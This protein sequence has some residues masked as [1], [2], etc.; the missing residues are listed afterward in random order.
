[1]VGRGRLFPGDPPELATRS[2]LAA[3][4]MRKDAGISAG[5]QVL[6]LNKAEFDQKTSLVKAMVC[7]ELEGDAAG[8]R[9]YLNGY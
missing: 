4:G 8:R 3:L 6:G 5:C 7:C 9:S 1:V 2:Y